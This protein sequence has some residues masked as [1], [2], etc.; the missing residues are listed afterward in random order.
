MVKQPICYFK[1]SLFMR[2]FI[3]SPVLSFRLERWS[4]FGLSSVLRECCSV[5]AVQ[6]GLMKRSL[7]LV[8]C[9]ACSKT[10]R[11]PQTHKTMQYLQLSVHRCC[12]CR[13]VHHLP[14]AH[15]CTPHCPLG[16]L[17]AWV[18]LHSRPAGLHRHR[19]G[20]A[21]A[22]SKPDLRMPRDEQEIVRNHPNLHSPQT[23][24]QKDYSCSP[25]TLSQAKTWWC[26]D[27]FRKNNAV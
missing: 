5:R 14:S 25:V 18:S 21:K 3:T 1:F 15:W 27:N 20:A 2:T 13:N 22:S 23:R 8:F 24:F 11:T 7:S 9:D 17:Y 6:R 12:K 10:S 26:L 19:F 4:L 16:L